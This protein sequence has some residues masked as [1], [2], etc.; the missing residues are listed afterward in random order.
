MKLI[1]SLTALLVL[2]SLT[3]CGDARAGDS[4]EVLM[5]DGKT[6]IE[7]TVATTQDE[8]RKIADA[9]MAQWRKNNPDRPRMKAAA[10]S[11]ATARA[12]ILHARAFFAA[13]PVTCWRPIPARIAPAKQT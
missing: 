5:C 10:P 1:V 3:S 4:V 2:A 13:S 6:T 11:A 8:G 12:K 7:A 9:L